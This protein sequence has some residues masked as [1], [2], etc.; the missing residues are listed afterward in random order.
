MLAAARTRNA[1]TLLAL[2]L[3][4]G[5]GIAEGAVLEWLYRVETPVPSRTTADRHTAAQRALDTMLTRLTGLAEVPRTPAISA[6]L[7]APERYYQRYSFVADAGETRLVV[8]FAPEALREL[9]A[10]ARLP[11]WAADRP[12]ALAWIVVED[13]L[14]EPA[15]ALPDVAADAPPG[16]AIP[17]GVRRPEEVADTSPAAPATAPAAETG[18]EAL[19]PAARSAT[20]ADDRHAAGAI[21]LASASPNPLATALHQRASERGIEILLP[22][23][24][25]ED[26]ERIQPT[27][28]LNGYDY[29]IREASARY[30]PDYIILGRVRRDSAAGW[31][32]DWRQWLEDTEQSFAFATPDAAISAIRAVDAAGDALA[33]RFAVTGAETSLVTLEVRGANSVA[34]YAGVLRH[35]EGLAF[36]DRVELV[37][38]QADAITLRVATRSSRTRLGNLLT[39]GDA[40]EPGTGAPTPNDDD[41]PMRL[42]W[43]AA[44]SATAQEARRTP[45]SPMRPLGDDLDPLA[46]GSAPQRRR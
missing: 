41:A 46:A 36:L 40:F 44:S 31:L 10:E 4:L 39:A 22:L 3:A 9:I 8:S 42:W 16:L 17:L 2:A 1:H 5:A 37:E 32:T 28:L 18:P 29:T 33:S 13:T 43:T 19:A 14:A 12:V 15:A 7:G 45:R 26:R 21:I 38:A 24:D 25:L 11:I 30:R 27:T 23:M 6:A 20:V 34:G 35:L